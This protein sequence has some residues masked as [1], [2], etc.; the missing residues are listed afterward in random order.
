MKDAATRAGLY[1]EIVKW[2]PIGPEIEVPD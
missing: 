2:M 1:P